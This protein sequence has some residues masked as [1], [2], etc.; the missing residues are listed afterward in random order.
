MKTIGVLGGMSN[1]ATSEYYR[2]INAGVNARLGGWNTAEVIINSVNFARIEEFVRTE[3]WDESGDYLSDK[4]R[5]L[6]RAGADF[7]LCVSNTMHRVAPAFTAAVEMP[8][9]HIADPTAQ[10]ILAAG[11]KR[12][13]LLGTL[14]IMA[15]DYMSGRYLEFGVETLVPSPDE[16]T[17]IDRM[18]FDELVKGAVSPASA[19]GFSQIVKRLASEGAEGVIL[20]CTEFF[21]LLA[22]ED[23]DGL[24]VFNT[25]ALHIEH[26]VAVALAGE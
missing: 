6:E 2:G 20:G 10:A 26:A 13:A 5:G 22:T 21:M 1:Q 3:R 15:A 24:P 19:K 8:F 7:F 25:T 12:V 11:L 18:I 9:L 14:P 17:V 4:A 23:F 16:Q